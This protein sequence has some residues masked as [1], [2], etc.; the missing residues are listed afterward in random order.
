MPIESHSGVQFTQSH[1]PDVRVITRHRLELEEPDWSALA[2]RLGR[3]RVLLVWGQGMRP[4]ERALAALTAFTESFDVAVIADHLANLH[5]DG[6]IDN[7]LAFL[8]FAAAIPVRHSS[9]TS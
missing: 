1:L 4:S 5:L 2:E 8:R 6:R 7:P 3:K 9:R